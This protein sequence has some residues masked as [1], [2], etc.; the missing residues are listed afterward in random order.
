MIAAG[1]SCRVMAFMMLA[2][3]LSEQTGHGRRGRS[4]DGPSEAQWRAAV[5][6]H[7]R[8]TYY[9][10]SEYRYLF[11]E[12]YQQVLTNASRLETDAGLGPPTRSR[13]DS[14]LVNRWRRLIARL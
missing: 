9:C 13:S 5:P 6:G 11:R 14:V 7:P 8:H 4:S 3:K 2:P 1:A 12:I 10:D